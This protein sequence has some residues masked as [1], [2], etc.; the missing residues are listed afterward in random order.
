MSSDRFKLSLKNRVLSK[1]AS[2]SVS[3]YTL[4]APK[5]GDTKE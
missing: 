4:N 2:A 1:D 5:I 3:Q